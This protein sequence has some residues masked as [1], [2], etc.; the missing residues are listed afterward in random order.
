MEQRKTVGYTLAIRMA[1]SF[2]T[3]GQ[4]IQWAANAQHELLNA[5]TE[6]WGFAT[7]TD[8][9]E[10]Y[11]AFV[12]AELPLVINPAFISQSRASQLMLFLEDPTQDYH[13]EMSTDEMAVQFLAFLEKE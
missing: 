6:K 7:K 10:N 8:I 5:Y 2:Q 4:V 11:R 1:N 13:L 12:R 9:W 3:I